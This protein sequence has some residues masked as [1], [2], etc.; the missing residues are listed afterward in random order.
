MNEAA[1][2]MN[3]VVCGAHMR[4][5]PLNHQLTD[6]GAEFVRFSKTAPLY[7]FYALE[8]KVKRPG[9]VRAP[10]GDGASIEVEIWRINREKVGGFLSYVLP[11]LCLGTVLLE[12]GESEIG[13]LCESIGAEGARDITR[14]GGWR[15]Y[16]ENA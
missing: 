8:D 16:L 9:L 14:F 6:L 7:R 12:D 10:E 11:P 2:E 1:D 15:S 3:L 13:F 5:L 4:G